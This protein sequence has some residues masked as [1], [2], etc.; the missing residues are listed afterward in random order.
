M[1]LDKTKFYLKAKTILSGVSISL[2][3]IPRRVGNRTVRIKFVG[4]LS[5]S[6]RGKA[7]VTV[8]VRI[9]RPQCTLKR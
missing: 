4:T 9:P 7:L 2:V 5:E 3:P 6:L 1:A 8:Q